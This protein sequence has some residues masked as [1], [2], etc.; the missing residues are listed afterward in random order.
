MLATAFAGIFMAISLSAPPGPVTMETVR[1]GLRGGFRPALYVQLGSVIGDLTWCGLALAGLAPLVQVAWV[2]ALLSVAGV[3]VLL[4]LGAAGLRDAFKAKAH[5]LDLGS[6]VHEHAGAFRSGVAI[7][8]ANPMAVAY[9]VSFGG[10]LVA[11]GV[12]GATVQQTAAFLLGYVGGTLAWCFVMA[13]A[14]R[15]GRLVFK[16]AVFH[17]VTLASSAAL[18]VFGGLLA[19]RLFEPLPA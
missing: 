17:W 14:V 5:S 18:L 11:A 19:W 12:A 9:W 15:F 6:S 10:A 2:R 1:R 13:L 16:P 4:Y 7:S 3:A 8:M